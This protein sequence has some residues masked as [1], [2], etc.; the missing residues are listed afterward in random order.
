MSSS[1][2]ATDDA[3]TICVTKWTCDVCHIASFDTYE[4]AEEHE[5]ACK[6]P[7]PKDDMNRAEDNRSSVGRARRASASDSSNASKGSVGADK[8][9]GKSDESKGYDLVRVTKWTCDV[10]RVAAFDSYYEALEHEKGCKRSPAGSSLPENP[11]WMML[12]PMVRGPKDSALYF[13]LATFNAT[14]LKCVKLQE[15]RMSTDTH[16]QAAVQR[17]VTFRCDFCNKLQLLPSITKWGPYNWTKA[18]FSQEMPNLLH[19]HLTTECTAVPKEII[20]NLSSAAN[21][22]H[23]GKMSLEKFCEK[24]FSENGMENACDVSSG[25]QTDFNGMVVLDDSEC[26]IDFMSRRS[27]WMRE[28]GMIIKQTAQSVVVEK[29]NVAQGKVMTKKV[30]STKRKGGTL[31]DAATN[32]LAAQLSESGSISLINDQTANIAN[33]LSP[34]LRLSMSQMELVG[35]AAS[36]LPQNMLRMY[37]RCK[38]CLSKT[39]LPPYESWYKGLYNMTH[40]HLLNTCSHMPKNIRTEL[41]LEQKKGGSRKGMG[42][43]RYCEHLSKLFELKNAQ[44]YSTSNGVCIYDNRSAQ[45]KKKR[46]S[47]TEGVAATKNPVGESNK[48]AQPDPMPAS[49]KRRKISKDSLPTSVGG[50]VHVDEDGMPMYLPPMGGVPL[51]SSQSMVQARKLSRYHQLLLD[52]IELF[53]FGAIKTAEKKGTKFVGIRC[54]NCNSNPKSSFFQPLTTVQEWHK[55]IRQAAAPHLVNCSCTSLSVQQDLIKLKGKGGKLSLKEYCE[56]LTTLYAMKNSEGSETAAEGVVW[57]NCSPIPVGYGGRPC[58]P[59]SRPENICSTTDSK[60]VSSAPRHNLMLPQSQDA[61]GSA[62]SPLNVKETEVCKPSP[63]VL[64]DYNFLLASQLQFVP[65]QRR[66][67][68]SHLNSKPLTMSMRQRTRQDSQSPPPSGVSP[69]TVDSTDVP[70]CSLSGRVVG[71]RCKHCLMTKPISSIQGC[72]NNNVYQFYAHFSKCPKFPTKLM[73]K[74]DECKQYQAMQRTP[75]IM[76]MPEY[77]R[78]VMVDVY[79]M[80]DLEWNGVSGGVGFCSNNDSAEGGKVSSLPVAGGRKVDANSVVLPV[81]ADGIV[82]PA[83]MGLDVSRASEPTAVVPA[84]AVTSETAVDLSAKAE[85]LAAIQAPMLASS[86]SSSAAAVEVPPPRCSKDNN[87]SPIPDIMAKNTDHLESFISSSEPAENKVDTKVVQSPTKASCPNS[88]ETTTND[89][90]EMQAKPKLDDSACTKEP[91]TAG[92]CTDSCLLAN[93]PSRPSMGLETVNGQLSLQAVNAN[94]DDGATV[95]VESTESAGVRETIAVDS[96]K[97][98]TMADRAKGSGNESS[99]IET[100]APSKEVKDA[101]SEAVMVADSSQGNMKASVDLGIPAASGHEGPKKITP[102]HES[103]GSASSMN[104]N[105]GP[106]ESSSA[107]GGSLKKFLS[108]KADSVCGDAPE[109]TEC[110]GT[111]LPSKEIVGVGGLPAKQNSEDSAQAFGKFLQPNLQC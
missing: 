111:E 46:K 71:I 92:T 5:N 55:I 34:L 9:E 91:N 94:G 96:S 27:Q 39:C 56:H 25:N 38:H 104:T 73:D 89:C 72:A 99:H 81:I 100:E 102:D 77:C 78:K 3:K 35:L 86:S 37:L 11:E 70:A 7:P 43:R 21:T 19:A 53:E 20:Q 42:L 24:F 93:A 109:W 10:C 36:E 107:G 90:G 22:K 63:M 59:S 106:D 88:E 14:L 23:V 31:V 82:E 12:A 97:G 48:H 67:S 61:V 30:E 95:V 57:G 32:K 101:G 69:S 18:T 2:T 13:N 45:S 28:K 65:V 68:Q 60:S 79:N 74:I 40:S 108:Q 26:Q 103:D 1:K 87:T 83:T 105:I 16:N 51:I 66:I 8:I 6:G 110:I 80:E 44:M 54:Q 33:Q 47:D 4:E 41:K 50:V 75:T 76:G 49:K 29:N 64:S 98:K 85:L 62:V 15:C 58:D 17:I 52:Q 84:P